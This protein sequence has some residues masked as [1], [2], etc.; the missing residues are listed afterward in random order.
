MRT[1]RETPARMIDGGKA[2]YG[3]FRT[4]FHAP[5][6]MDATGIPRCLRPWRLKEW[7]HWGLLHPE[8]YVSIALVD[9]KFLA[10]AWVSVFDRRARRI[11]EHARKVPLG[12]LRIPADVYDGGVTFDR[13]GFRV[14]IRNELDRGSHR[15]SIDVDA[16][17]NLPAIRGEVVAQQDMAAIHPL[18]TALT[19]GPGKPF[20]SHKAP[21]PLSGTLDIGTDRVTF[22][23][24]R[25]FAILDEHKAFYPRNTFWRWATFACRDANG[26]VLGV[27]LTQNV[28][29]DDAEQNENAIWHGNRL[30]PLG[31]ARFEIPASPD[32]PWRIRTQDGRVDLV[33]QPHGARSEDLNLLIAVSKFR[34][35][36]GVFTGT[37]VDDDGVRHVVTEALGV[38]ED[39][40]V[41]W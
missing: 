22:D 10:T 8:V 40:R 18:V 38:V 31:A 28:I 19:F 27:N 3:M 2:A 37:L 14:S 24:A 34:Q 41:T 9:A 36:V 4:P 7:Q 13:Q 29:A 6:L 30:S 20:Y 39:H 16:R 15:I 21:C 25:D 5:N 26:E 17:D 35:P 1:I 12:A 33:F 11:F 32:A 23:A